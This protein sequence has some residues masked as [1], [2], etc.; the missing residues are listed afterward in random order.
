M[1][2]PQYGIWSIWPQL[3]V[4]YHLF[5]VILSAVSAYCLFS[6]TMT[7][8]RLRSH[9]IS[10]QQSAALHLR[11]ANTGRLIGAMFWV[12]G[13][14]FFWGLQDLPHY[15]GH[16]GSALVS[17]QVLGSFML[18]FAFAWNVFSVFLVLHLVHWFV[19]SRLNLSTSLSDRPVA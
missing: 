14:V 16:G 1:S 12:F 19:C 9:D 2:N 6:A 10:A 15:L 13:V 4:L 5:F 11:W 3:S 7:V 17:L 18:H 8:L